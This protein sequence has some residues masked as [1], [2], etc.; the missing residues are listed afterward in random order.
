[1]N[2]AFAVDWTQTRNLPA[3][4]LVLAALVLAGVIWSILRDRGKAT[5]E[6]DDER[7]QRDRRQAQRAALGG[8]AASAVFVLLFWQGPWWFDGLHIRKVD[9]QPADGVII[10]GFRTGLV[11]LA[12]GLIA[13]ATLYY[14]HKK[15]QLEQQQFQHAQ[16]QFAENQKQFETTLRE[17][18]ARDERQAELTREGQVTGRYV[19]A[20]KLLAS[21]NLAERLG[22]IYALERIMGDSQKDYITVVSVLTAYLREP[23]DFPE[24][25]VSSDRQA[26]F[27]VLGRRPE[28]VGRGHYELDFQGA[29]LKGIFGNGNYERANFTRADLTHARLIDCHA[30][31]INFCEAKL[32]GASLMNSSMPDADFSRAS[33][34]GTEL[35]GHAPRARY[36]GTDLTKATYFPG[37]V[38]DWYMDED[39]KLPEV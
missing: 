31:S 34:I 4:G 26:A 29:H 16:Q 1:M 3:A 22:G 18:Q 30:P 10:T 28:Y 27:T 15:H 39:T 32:D 5:P 19:E 36:F 38:E 24:K 17:T 25:D 14:T 7:Q 6:A 11:A 33:L 13:G 9:L 35:A 23:V 37:V 12:A 2:P 21:T 20:I 8:I